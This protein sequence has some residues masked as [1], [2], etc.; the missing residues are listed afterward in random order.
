MVKDVKQADD[1]LFKMST[2]WFLTGDGCCS[3]QQ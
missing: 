2:D 3:M 1:C